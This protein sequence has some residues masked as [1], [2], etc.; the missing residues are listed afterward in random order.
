MSVIDSLHDHQSSFLR[1][2]EGWVS[3]PVRQEP[4]GRVNAGAR[5]PSVARVAKR[6]P[7]GALE[8]RA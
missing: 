7:V 1:W 4:R 5:V 3:V 8:V 2:R 6:R